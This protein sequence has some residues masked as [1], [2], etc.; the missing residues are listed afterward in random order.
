M[1]VLL[2]LLFAGF[3]IWLCYILN[4]ETKAFPNVK[5]TGHQKVQPA[6][7]EVQTCPCSEEQVLGVPGD[8]QDESKRRPGKPRISSG[9]G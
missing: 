3:Y 5:N 8:L 9:C 4:Q 2:L 7:P 1:I 6:T